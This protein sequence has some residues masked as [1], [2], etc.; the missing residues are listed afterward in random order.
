[1]APLQ[2]FAR[3]RTVTACLSAALVREPLGHEALLEN[4]W[5]TAPNKGLSTKPSHPAV[6]QPSESPK[7][8]CANVT[9]KGNRL[10]NSNPIKPTP[11]AETTGLNMKP[12]P[13]KTPN[14]VPTQRRQV[15]KTNT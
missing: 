14:T 6:S 15:P 8:A 1:M 9:V 12:K 4:H 11:K 5:R 7:P 13:S 3:I 10:E 2:R